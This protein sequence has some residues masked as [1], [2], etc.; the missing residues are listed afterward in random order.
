MATNRATLKTPSNTPHRIERVLAKVR[1][2]QLELAIK[3]Q[4]EDSARY[5]CLAQR[6][7]RQAARASKMNP[8]CAA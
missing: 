1:Q 4:I 5:A 7:R 3:G 8:C 6:V 2:R